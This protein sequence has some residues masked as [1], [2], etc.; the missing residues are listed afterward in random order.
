MREYAKTCV[1]MRHRS[2]TLK[3]SCQPNRAPSS[4]KRG[5]SPPET[6]LPRRNNYGGHQPSQTNPDHYPR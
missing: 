4:T 5:G 1:Q 2:R 3:A 6:N